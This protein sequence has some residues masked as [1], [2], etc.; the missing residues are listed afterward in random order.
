M[1]YN[2]FMK[3]IINVI[4]K[5]ILSLLLIMPILGVLKVFPEPT[6]NLYKTKEAYDFV[7]ILMNSGYV[8]WFMTIVFILC[9]FFII[10]NKMAIVALLLLPIT[11]NILGFHAFLDG[12]LFS[13]G[14]IMGEIFFLINIYFLWQNRNQY[15]GLF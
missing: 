15:K 10:K 1:L 14:A 13:S 3:K 12:G 2:D 6:P 5:I 9:L 8:M 7:M 11:L 4:L